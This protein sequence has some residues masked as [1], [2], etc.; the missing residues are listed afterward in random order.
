M[1]LSWASFRV[2]VYRERSQEEKQEENHTRAPEK[3]DS[4]IISWE[5]GA[6]YVVLAQKKL[7]RRL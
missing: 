7:G 5:F 1:A 6:E 3:T 4:R 2:V